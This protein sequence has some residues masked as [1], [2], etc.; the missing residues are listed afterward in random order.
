MNKREFLKGIAAAGVSSLVARHL[1]ADNQIEPSTYTYKTVGSCEIRLDAYTPRN[2]RRPAIIWIHGGALITGT[3]LSPPQWLNRDG[4]YAIVSIDYRLAPESKLAAII[5][6]VADAYCWIV[7]HEAIL[8]IETDRIAVAGQSAGGYLS[9]MAGLVATKRKPKALLALSGYGSVVGE[10]YSRPSAVYLKEPKVSREEAF[11]SVGTHCYSGPSTLSEQQLASSRNQFYLYCRQ[12][13]R[14][15]QE[16]TGHDPSL[17]SGWFNRYCPV[18]NISQQ[19][20]PTVLIHGTS[21][22][23]V[24]YEESAKL[25]EELT[26]FKV[27]HRLIS[28]PGGSHC[29]ADDPPE[30]KAAVMQ[31]AMKFVDAHVL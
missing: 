12:Q 29:L 20:P 19:F 6:D 28:V 11:K 18:R 26:R 22:T 27:E 3:R 16:V 31:A 1:W 7:A 13:G 30:V 10:W 23:D 17:D 5:E 14:W 21:D 4:K 8:A 25:D 2:G 24:P 15:P 9:L